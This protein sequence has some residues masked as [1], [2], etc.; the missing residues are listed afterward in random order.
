MDAPRSGPTPVPRISRA[1]RDLPAAIAVGLALGAA[2]LVSL[3]VVRQA[4]IGLVAAAIAVAT[5]E[6]VG[7]LRRGGGIR[8]PLVLVLAGGQ[9]MIWLSWPFGLQGI[10]VAFAITALACVVWRLRGGAAGYLR[11]VTGSLFT[12]AYVPMFAAFAAMLAVP[13]DGAGRVVCFILAVVASDTGGYAA[14]VLR[15]RHPMAPSISPRKSWEGF[16]GS[17][18]A[19]VGVGVLTITYLVDGQP[20][21]GVLFGAAIVCTATIGDLVESMIKRDLGVKDMGWLLPGHGGMMERL[22]SM[23]PS[24]VVSWLLLTLFV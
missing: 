5:W 6:L 12:A 10:F 17:L 7:A 4:F 1:G 13:A 8:V 16:G 15:G 24:A 14:G 20:W 2:I 19:G 9:A 21:Q 11:D 18:L 3:F 22:D 23:L